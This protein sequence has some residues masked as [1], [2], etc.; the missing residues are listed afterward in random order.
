MAQLR[1]GGSLDLADPL[2]GEV[3][4]GADLLQ[5]AG[6]APVQTEAEA[7]DLPLALTQRRQKAVDLAASMASATRS[8]GVGALASATTS[9]SSVSPSLP[10]G[11]ARLTGSAT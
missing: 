1:Q 8:N 10:T 11:V 4:G 5:R 9:P 6:F 3:E 7:Q 2:P